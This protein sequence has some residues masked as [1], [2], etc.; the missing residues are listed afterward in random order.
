MIFKTWQNFY[1]CLKSLNIQ[2]IYLRTVENIW[3]SEQE[4]G[5]SGGFVLL[6]DWKTS[7]C[8]VLPTNQD[9]CGGHLE[10]MYVHFKRSIMLFGLIIQH[11]KN[12]KKNRWCEH[13]EIKPMV[14]KFRNSCHKRISQKMKK[15]TFSRPPSGLEDV[16]A[17]LFIKKQ[18][19]L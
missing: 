7:L 5:P 3:L 14:C 10:Y 12:V 1:I 6:E 9:T 16:I 19:R 15:N 18:P 17:H 4:L 8:P 13:L 2:R 11:C